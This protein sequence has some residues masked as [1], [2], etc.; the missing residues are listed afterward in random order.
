MMYKIIVYK[1]YQYSFLSCL[2]CI[3]ALTKAYFAACQGGG[4]IDPEEKNFT[5]GIAPGTHDENR[6]SISFHLSSA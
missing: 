5:E 2:S 4:S 3:I 1:G 6:F